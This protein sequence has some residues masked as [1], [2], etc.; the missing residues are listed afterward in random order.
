ML[1]YLENVYLNLKETCERLSEI[2]GGWRDG[3]VNREVVEE[4]KER[5]QDRV[6]L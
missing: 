6:K 5:K 2:V 3:D 1:L 4:G